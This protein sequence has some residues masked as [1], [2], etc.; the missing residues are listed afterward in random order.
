MKQRLASVAGVVALLA[1]IVAVLP[2]YLL[3]TVLPF[4]EWSPGCLLLGCGHVPAGNPPSTWRWDILGRMIG[5]GFGIY[6]LVGLCGL[7]RASK[8]KRAWLQ[9][10][11]VL[12]GIAL[13]AICCAFVAGF[14]MPPAAFDRIM[15][16]FTG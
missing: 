9:D 2:F 6:Y 10:S 3:G 14:V 15:A 5:F 8:E 16:T 11:R 12:G 1:L 13:L 7:P 4:I